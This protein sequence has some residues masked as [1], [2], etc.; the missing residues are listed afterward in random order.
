MNTRVC[1]NS[2]LQK[3]IKISC[4]YIRCFYSYNVMYLNSNE[5]KGQQDCAMNYV[6]VTGNDKLIYGVTKI[7]AFMSNDCFTG[8]NRGF[9]YA[10]S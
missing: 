5:I 2:Y 4:S 7:T 6:K 9:V 10:S 8:I 3:H 1:L